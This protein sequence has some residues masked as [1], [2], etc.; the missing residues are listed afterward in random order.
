M[1]FTF[2][3]GQRGGGLKVDFTVFTYLIR[4]AGDEQEEKNRTVI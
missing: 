4:A 2:S 3:K 1:C